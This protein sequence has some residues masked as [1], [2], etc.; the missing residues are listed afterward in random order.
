MLKRRDQGVEFFVIV[1]EGCRP[2]L[3]IELGIV[4]PVVERQA[5][6]VEMSLVEANF[7]LRN[8]CGKQVET[9]NPIPDEVIFLTLRSGLVEGKPVMIAF[10]RYLHPAIRHL[11]G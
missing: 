2:H 11:L 6:P 3:P 1:G 7:G 5:E 10:L 9:E 4:A 8:L